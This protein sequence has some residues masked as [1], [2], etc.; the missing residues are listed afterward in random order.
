LKRILDVVLSV[1]I[2]L[3]ASPLIVVVSMAIWLDTGFPI[4]FRQERV[5]LGFKRFHILKFRT[6]LAH[7]SGPR[8]TVRGDMRVTRIG[9]ILRSMKIDEVPQFWNVL[10]GD[11]SIVGPRPEVPEY[12]E[13][14]KTRYENVLRVRPG[15]TD[16]A[17]IAFRDEEA[18]LSRSND[19]LREYREHILPAKLD[20]ADRYVSEQNLVLDLVIIMRTAIAAFHPGN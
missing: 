15:I 16:F 3:I 17:S 18:L 11:M 5:G 10:R 7:D 14:F 20:L 1:C 19:P 12:V 2:L 9:A 4:F 13:L 8:V 6:M